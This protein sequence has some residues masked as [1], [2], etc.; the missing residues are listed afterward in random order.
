MSSVRNRRL[1]VIVP[2]EEG[3]SL[4]RW[5]AGRYTYRSLEAWREEIAAGR[6]MIG[7]AETLPDTILLRGME[8]S[9]D[10][11]PLP[12]PPVNSDYRLV[13][14]D[15]SLLVVDKPA[16]L[17]CHSG[18]IYLRNTLIDLLRK[19][20][21]EVYLA[22]RLDR[23][24]AGLMLV[25]R[26]RETATDLFAQ[27]KERRVEKEYYALV[28]GSFPDY[29]DAVGWLS[30]DES[31]RIRKKRA[32]K[33]DPEAVDPGDAGSPGRQYCRTEIRLIREAEGLSLLRC[34][35][36]TGKTHQI[37]ASL[38][39]LGFPLVGDKIY[40]EDETI[41][42]R[43]ARGELTSEDRELLILENQALFSARLVFTHPRDGGPLRFE[44]PYPLTWFKL[45]P[46]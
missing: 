13:F 11:P 22:N 8:V 17:P 12:E 19:D 18:G 42:L 32:F 28:R 30:K 43:F 31:S 6:I 1:T 36:H 7:G 46:E 9:Y 4:D 25:A 38:C 20:F 5:L 15:E 21:G 27:F 24:T 2:H 41:F 40:G 10:P 33:L 3:L 44:L 26:N 34:R 45:V 14:Q 16:D 23:E 37:R 39:S 35:L 29:L